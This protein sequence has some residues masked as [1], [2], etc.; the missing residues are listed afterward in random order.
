MLLDWRL[1]QASRWIFM[2]GYSE[3]KFHQVLT[4][5]PAGRLVKVIYHKGV[6]QITEGA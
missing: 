5:V 6:M 1:K 2:S 3:F 4:R